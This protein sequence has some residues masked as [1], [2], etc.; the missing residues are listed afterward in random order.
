VAAVQDLFSRRI[1]GWA[2]DRHMRQELVVAALQVAVAAR[3]PGK[4]TIHHSDHGGQY[5]GL[6]FSETCH[7]AGSA[8]QRRVYRSRTS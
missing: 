2:M 7:D 1:V 8:Q 5:V 3:R 6:T 4:G